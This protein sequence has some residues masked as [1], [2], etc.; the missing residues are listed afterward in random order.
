MRNIPRIS[1]WSSAVGLA[2]EGFPFIYN[3]CRRFQ[4]D[5]FEIKV[6]FLK[7]LC[8]SGPEASRIFYDPERFVRQGA[9]PKRIQRTLFGE[10]GVQTLDDAAHRRRKELFMSIMTP[11]NIQR[12]SDVMHEQWRMAIRKWAGTAGPIILFDELKELLC[13]AACAW[14]GVPISESEVKQRAGQFWERVDAFGAV[15]LR[16]LRGR[17]AR[18]QTEDWMRGIILGIREGRITVPEGTS[19]YVMALHREPDSKPLEAQVAAVELIN[20][21]RPIVAIANYIVFAALALHEHPECRNGLQH[22]GPDDIERFV[23]EVRRYYPFAPF[24]GAKVRSAFDWRN[25]H[26]P[27]GAMVLLDV[28]GTNRHPDTWERPLEFWPDRFRQW[29]GS[30]YNFIPQGGGD[31]YKN[32]RCA[33]EWVTIETLKIALT[34]LTKHMEY[35]VPPQDLSFKLSR[36]PTFP[37]S[38]FI[39]TQVREKL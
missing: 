13:R 35:T 15:G 21:V 3:R 32:H 11:E 17:K 28:Y 10:K 18:Q 7:V 30:A 23:Q 8:M 34:Y 20:T 4:S 9:I 38:G 31:H 22:G 5:L 2:R 6:P 1:A 24:L 16:H 19:A 36:M 14:A 33:G 29:D 39:I 26:F 27:K 37:R 12:L 25:V